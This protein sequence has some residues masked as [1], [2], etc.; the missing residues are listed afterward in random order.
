[1]KKT[2]FAL[3]LVAV[4]GPCTQAVAS[5][6]SGRVDRVLIRFQGQIVEGTT[7]RPQI[8]GHS[9]A[10]QISAV[11]SARS[12]MQRASGRQAGDEVMIDVRD[13]PAVDGRQDFRRQ[14]VTLTYR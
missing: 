1:M 14:L 9:T 10:Q 5:E 12:V 4:I 11:C 8:R 3:M 2:G 13:I 6:L 7:C